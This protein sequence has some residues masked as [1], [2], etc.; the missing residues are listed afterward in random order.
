M[1]VS[2]PKQ[3]GLDLIEANNKFALVKVAQTTRV[4]ILFVLVLFFESADT[5]AAR[6]KFILYLFS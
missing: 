5:A 1:A 6:R 4:I 3:Y 2:F